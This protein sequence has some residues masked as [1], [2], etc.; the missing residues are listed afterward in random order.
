MDLKVNRVG[1]TYEYKYGHYY[2][3]MTDFHDGHCEIE[4]H[5]CVPE[6]LYHSCDMKDIGD[7]RSNF[8]NLVKGEMRSRIL[9]PNGEPASN[10]G[11]SLIDILREN[12]E[13][14][15]G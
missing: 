12:E 1:T 9:L 7:A 3:S 14:I 13:K 11:Q 2:L 15:L 10:N 5:R 6:Q 4:I 8:E